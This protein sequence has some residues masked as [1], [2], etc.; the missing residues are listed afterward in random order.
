MIEDLDDGAEG[1]MALPDQPRFTRLSA[2]TWT[3]IL[4]DYQQ[5]ATAP[6][7][8]EKWGVRETTV[9]SRIMRHNATKSSIGDEM[10]RQRAEMITKAEETRALRREVSRSKLFAD[11]NEDDG[12]DPL[13]LTLLATVGSGRAMLRQLWPE[14]RVLARLAEVYARLHERKIIEIS[15]EDVLAAPERLAELRTEIDGL[16]AAAPRSI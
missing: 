6:E 8:A 11:F 3:R 7:L 2:E 14:A 10:A 16:A 15:L 5:G 4:N 13:A 12:I 9:R 1:A